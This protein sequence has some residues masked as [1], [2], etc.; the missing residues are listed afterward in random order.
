M[1]VLLAVQVVVLVMRMMQHRR[2]PPSVGGE[3]VWVVAVE[4]E[5]CVELVRLLRNELAR[6]AAAARRGGE[7]V[8]VDASEASGGKRVRH[9][10]RR[11]QRVEALLT[12][13]PLVERCVAW[14]ALHGA[15]SVAVPSGRVLR[16]VLVGELGE[17]RTV[18]LVASL[19]QEGVLLAALPV[20]QFAHSFALRSKLEGKLVDDLEHL[21][22]LHALEG[23]A[24]TAQV[25]EQLLVPVHDS[26]VHDEQH[27]DSLGAVRQKVLHLDLHLLLR[28]ASACSVATD[29]DSDT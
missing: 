26:P 1:V 27:H 15:N 24:R 23:V 14:R 28:V 22:R 25:H 10:R 16:H 7:L 20:Q 18:A 2:H 4:R 21:L 5:N 12:A 17:Q 3:R 9:C 13:A 6:R 29:S 8:G 19:Q 11:P